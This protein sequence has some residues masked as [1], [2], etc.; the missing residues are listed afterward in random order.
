[1][2]KFKRLWCTSRGL[3]LLASLGNV[4]NYLYATKLWNN[5]HSSSSSTPSLENI[6]QFSSH[7][8]WTNQLIF[9]VFCICNFRMDKK[10]YIFQKIRHHAQNRVTLQGLIVNMIKGGEGLYDHLMITWIFTLIMNKKFHMT[11][12]NHEANGYGHDPHLLSISAQIVC[13]LSYEKWV[14]KRKNL[15]NI[16]IVHNSFSTCWND[17]MCWM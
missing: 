15:D 12:K 16:I 6:A 3:D 8:F 1:M 13:F 4:T 17:G 7:S 2:F 14:Q 10:R 11:S 9:T 5:L